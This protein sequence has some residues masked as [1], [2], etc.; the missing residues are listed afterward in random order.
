MGT[1]V[2]PYVII[3]ILV[4]LSSSAVRTSRL[5]VYRLTLW[6]SVYLLAFGILTGSFFEAISLAMMPIAVDLFSRQSPQLILR[7]TKMAVVVLF[8]G[9]ALNL[10]TEEVL[11]L[12][13]SNYRTPALRAMNSFASEASYLGL[14]GFTLAVI[15]HELRAGWGW[16]AA[17]TAVVMASGSAAAILPML[18]FFALTFLR[19]WRLVAFP[20]GLAV[21]WTGL[22]FAASSISRFGLLA[23]TLLHAPGQILL[24]VSFS[25]RIMRTFGPIIAGFRDGLVPHGLT[26]EVITSFDMLANQANHVVVRLSNLGTVLVYGL[27]VLSFPLIIAYLRMVKGSLA[28]WFGLAYLSVANLSLATPYVWLAF[29]IPLLMKRQLTM[30]VVTP[31]A[32]QTEGSS[33]LRTNG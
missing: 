8:V 28:L 4:A 19:G 31:G 13:V 2:Q 1:D 33:P 32:P 7:G 21:I 6:F 9:L 5:P 26:A 20:V 27:G 30:G 11:P 24:D 23:D 25:N 29:S 12:V 17:A 14:I 22:E 3:G 10:A 18:T 15:F 16:F